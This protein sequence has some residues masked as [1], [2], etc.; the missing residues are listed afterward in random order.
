MAEW[1]QS[2]ESDPEDDDEGP[3]G[4]DCQN[5]PT[6]LAMIVGLAGPGLNRRS[7]RMS[8]LRNEGS[9]PSWEVGSEPPG[10]RGVAL[11]QQVIFLEALLLR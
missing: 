3:H 2:N 11:D 6:H 5:P 4:P 1:D 8:C 7:R 10:Y 9:D